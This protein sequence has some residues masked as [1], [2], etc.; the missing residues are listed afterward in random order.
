[1]A[2]VEAKTIDSPFYFGKDQCRLI[3][4]SSTDDL[5]NGTW[6]YYLL[7]GGYLVGLGAPLTAQYTLLYNIVQ[8][9]NVLVAI[10]VAQNPLNISFR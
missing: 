8:Q 5:S 9:K 6:V 1:L 4:I 2:Q 7:L 10:V 3:T